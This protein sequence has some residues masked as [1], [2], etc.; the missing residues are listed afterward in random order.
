MAAAGISRGRRWY[1]SFAATF[2]NGLFLTMVVYPLF[3][4]SAGFWQTVVIIILFEFY[5]DLVVKHV[6]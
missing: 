4:I 1:G 5:N 2:L 3:H 6:R